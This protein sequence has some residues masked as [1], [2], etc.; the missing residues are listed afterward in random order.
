MSLL[1][2][3]TDKP[4]IFRHSKKLGFKIGNKKHLRKT[5][6]KCFVD[7]LFD[8]RALESEYP[9]LTFDIIKY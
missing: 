9:I 2:F 7:G 4:H 6:V 3:R 8:K 5:S 1:D